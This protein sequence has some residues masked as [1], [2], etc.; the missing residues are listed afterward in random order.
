MRVPDQP[1]SW[2]YNPTRAVTSLIVPTAAGVLILL[3]ASPQT[4]VSWEALETRQVMIA[5]VEIV[6]NDVFDLSRP[7]ENYWF[8]R[9]ANTAHVETRQRVIARE[10]LFAAGEPVDAERIRET[11]RNLRRHAFIRDARIVPVRPEGSTVSARIEVDDAWSLNGN[12][13]LSQSGG[14]LEWSAR[15]D[16]M[17]LLGTG[18]RVFYAHEENIERSANEIG[19]I[20][21]QL[22]GS[23]WVLSA[24]YGDLSDG[25]TR[26]LA[27]ERPYFSIETP[28][29]IGGFV[30]SSERLLTQYN[31]GVA[32]NVLPSRR[33]ATA[34]SASVAYR[35]R[36]RTA[37]RLG[38]AYRANES[39]Y[40][41]PVVLVPGSLPAPDTSTR[42]VRGVSANWSLVQDRSATFQN[43]ARIG[44]T[45]DYNLGWAL[46]AGAGYAATS[47][48][49]TASAP[50]GDAT[51]RK[52]WSRGSRTLMVVDVSARGRHEDDG[53]RDA[54]GRAAVTVYHRGPAGQTV[55]AQLSG[56][57]STRPDA[58]DWLYLGG[59]DG[60]RG[61][62][63]HYLA[64]DRRL[65]VSLEDRV[66]TSWRPFGLVQAGFVAYVDAGAI[67]RAD[68]GTWSRTYANVGAG[69]RFGAL[70]SGGGNLLMISVATPLVRDP[71]I[72][73][74]L[75]VLG[76]S[77]GF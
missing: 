39:E 36:D 71:G 8:S 31:H 73:K 74:L 64:G 49:S 34:A 59:R 52:G 28:Y 26:L 46:S 14:N 5:A 47:L 9:L 2:V 30:T 44:R 11:E 70:K 37:H 35:V 55:A 65:T 22:F 77:V 43:F 10:L 67:R 13:D 19:Y 45:E 56:V 60:L 41:P 58:E 72:D 1:A 17:N 7:A 16:E 66:V 53:W 61:Y 50:F 4:D 12:L 18:K 63:D 27:A 69:L 62:V 15:V 48:G 24:A 68:T 6:V 57:S 40:D 25:S 38:V 32:V 21:P 54:V 20:D 51:V 23:R 76:N 75:L 33:S 3:A 42:R 29:A